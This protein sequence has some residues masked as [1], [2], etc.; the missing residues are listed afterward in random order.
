[1]APGSPAD[2]AGIH[3]GD[4]VVEVNRKKVSSVAE[5]RDEAAKVADGKPLLLLVR[6]TDG[7][8]RFAALTAG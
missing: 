3:G 4:I 5:V 7:N 8:D 1:V 6:P 2:E